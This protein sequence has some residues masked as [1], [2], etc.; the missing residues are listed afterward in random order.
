MSELGTGKRFN[1]DKLRYDLIN[2]QATEGLV[3]VLTAGSKKYSCHNWEKGMNWDIVLASL[4]RHI[5]AFEA[6]ED[7]D[8]ET[9]ELHVDHI[10]C[11]AH[12]LSAYVRVFPQGDNRFQVRRVKPKIGLDVDDVLADF[13]GAWCAKYGVQRPEFWRFDKDMGSR[14]AELKE[15]GKLESFYIG[16]EALVKPNELSFEPS[17]YIS[18]RPVPSEITQDWL[19]AHGFPPAPVITVGLGQ[20]KVEA[21]KQAGVDI[22]I[23]DRYENYEELNRNGVCCF[24]LDRPHNARYSVGYKRIKQLKEFKI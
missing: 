13:I 22:F 23:D 14:F 24:L 8:Q 18:S 16:L 5:A 9:G 17:C 11:N 1:T 20:S 7:Y 19:T 15:A 21:A 2:P 6:G 10:Q 12:F 4:K 3:R